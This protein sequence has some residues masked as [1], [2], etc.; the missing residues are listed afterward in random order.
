[1]DNLGISSTLAQGNAMTQNTTDYNERIHKA[2][3]DVTNF[4]T[5][6]LQKDSD[7]QT[8]DDALFGV[9][10]AI[11][12]AQA[13][14]KM[15]QLTDAYGDY[16]NS[17]N[18]GEFLGKQVARGKEENPLAFGIF[19]GAKNAFINP[20]DRTTDYFKGAKNAVKSIPPPTGTVTVGQGI[21]RPRLPIGDLQAGVSLPTP[22]EP[23]LAPAIRV[24]QRTQTSID[25]EP[26]DD[27]GP[28]PEPEPLPVNRESTT[29][30]PESKLNTSPINDIE[31]KIPDEP[32]KPTFLGKAGEVLDSAGG[33]AVQ[34]IAGNISGGVD[35][36]DYFKSGEKFQEAN[37]AEDWGDRLTG[38]GTI[39]DI[40]GTA[41]PGLEAIGGLMSAAGALS[42]TIGEHEADTTKV[43]LTDP[44]A[45]KT[46]L[47][48]LQTHA[49]TS[50]QGLGQVA[51]QNQHIQA[52]SG[53]ASF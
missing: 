5:A 42:T 38:L 48:Q 50:L 12:S 40:V 18:L 27:E 37:S 43:N 29:I 15:N 45:K 13:G 4:Y 16:K 32:A 10:D 24:G 26:V 14:M 52:M 35:I 19:K 11:A 33:K 51:T 30:P 31:D 9:K 2:R 47:N 44:A 39:F 20:L 22:Q 53:V 28:E 3:D 34:K 23:A 49:Q 36:Y 8:V 21:T 6:Q 41:I 1:M 46:Q 17:E 7:Q 25:L